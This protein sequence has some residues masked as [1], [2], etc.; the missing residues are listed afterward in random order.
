MYL[1]ERA[2]HIQTMEKN[3][4]H[5]QSSCVYLNATQQPTKDSLKLLL[6]FYFFAAAEKLDR[7]FYFFLSFFFSYIS[8]CLLIIPFPHFFISTYSASTRGFPTGHL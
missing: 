5:I 2:E 3:K 6:H 1:Q 7:K 8:F 4:K